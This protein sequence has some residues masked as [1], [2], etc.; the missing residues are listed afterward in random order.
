VAK[1]PYLSL[2]AEMNSKD[3]YQCEPQIRRGE[4]LRRIVFSYRPRNEKPC[5]N[6]E[7]KSCL[8]NYAKWCLEATQAPQLVSGAFLLLLTNS[9]Q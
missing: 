4:S 2:V 3:K 9:K 8:S 5:L 6:D 1:A 7:Q